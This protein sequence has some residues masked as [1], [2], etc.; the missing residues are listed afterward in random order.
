ME[1]SETTLAHL[2][3][4]AYAF[5][6]GQALLARLETLG[7]ERA[8]V[9]TTRPP[10]GGVLASRASRETYA[11]SMR[12]VDDNEAVLR[13]QLAQITGIGDWLRPIIRKDVST[14]LA[15][16]S[17]DYCRLLQIA[18][19]I[20]DWERAYHSVPELLVAFARDLRAVRLALAAAKKTPP[21]VAHEL[22]HL[23]ESAERL[24]HRHHELHVIERAALA[25][26][27]VGIAETVQ[28]P[29]L[30]DLQRLSW[31]SRLAVIPPD[32]ALAEVTRVEAEMRAFLAGPSDRVVARLQASRA[33]CGKIVE[34]T[35]E[36]YW[37]QLRA[38]ARAH[39]VEERDVSDIIRMLSERYIDAD[40]QRRQLE[41]TA[42]PFKA[43]LMG[44]QILSG[45]DLAG[46]E[47]V[48]V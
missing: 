21:P 25:L 39:Y 17:P 41:V 27:P 23:R 45:R 15:S 22:A 5:L 28:F 43:R 1:L 37:K 11:R 36:E 31:V 19:R 42:D 13:D 48:K 38:H 14:Y 26:L 24:A 44:N 8:N 30:P 46:K 6:A 7:R 29:E 34:Q 40:I 16:V 10:F 2:R 32:M 33:G 9:E 47:K 4:E 12:S 20:D 35:L 3:D 18:A